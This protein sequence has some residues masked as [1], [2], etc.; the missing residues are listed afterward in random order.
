M[1]SHRLRLWDRWCSL[2]PPPTRKPARQRDCPRRLSDRVSVDRSRIRPLWRRLT[3][4]R[5]RLVA[6]V[7]DVPVALRGLQPAIAGTQSSSL[8][9]A[10]G[11]LHLSASVHP[12][13]KKI[14]PRGTFSWWVVFVYATRTTP[15]PLAISRAIHATPSIVRSVKSCTAKSVFRYADTK[16]CRSA[17]TS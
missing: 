6:D 2:R 14:T 8:S 11:F 5:T 12:P 7:C 4:L 16:N 13:T 9:V 3:E 15:T 1:L 10:R 17:N